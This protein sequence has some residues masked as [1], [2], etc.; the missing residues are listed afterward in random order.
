ML[1]DCHSSS[2]LVGGYPPA[3]APPFLRSFDIGHAT[4]GALRGSQTLGGV[5]VHTR[6]PARP[7]FAPVPT[8]PTCRAGSPPLAPPS[9]RAD[10]PPRGA[11]SSPPTRS[12]R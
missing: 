4:L 7:R 8:Q 6:A 1:A 3:R 12:A 9:T 5:R 2:Q 10:A 11:H